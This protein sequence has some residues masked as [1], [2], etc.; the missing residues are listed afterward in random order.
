MNGEITDAADR[1]RD[2]FDAGQLDRMSYDFANEQLFSNK[3]AKEVNVRNQD[4][5]PVA[6]ELVAKVK[7]LPYWAW[8]LLAVGL[9]VWFKPKFLSR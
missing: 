5:A 4:T 8:I 3:I 2:A 1:L 6:D 9:A 7:S